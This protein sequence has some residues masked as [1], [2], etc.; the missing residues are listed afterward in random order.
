MSESKEVATR[1]P[2]DLAIP[3]EDLGMGFEDMQGQ[4]FA[5]PFLV[6]C[7]TTSPYINPAHELYIPEARPGTII[8]TMNNR[9]YA[10]VNVIPCKYAFRAVEWK[11]RASG[12][13]F[14]SSYTREEIP[15]D[16]SVNAI[17]GRTQRSNGNEI[18]STGY[19]LCLLIEEDFER[20]IVPMTSTQLK[21]SRK[22]N[23]MMMGQKKDGKPLPIFSKIYELSLVAEQ[24]NKG[25]WFG[26]KFDIV[27]NT[28]PEI[29]PLAKETNQIGN[30][31]PDQ[32]I[33]KTAAE[34]ETKEGVI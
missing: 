18:M 5:A 29:Y 22:W 19:Y 34:S 17:T 2:T 3:D 33:A 25:S 24:N 20:V 21:K 32:L 15:D 9:V 28:D 13:G 26:W 8:N 4:D 6:I 1:Q 14:V 30:F 7:Q 16:L 31:L 10:K 11:P 23:T 27:D 12:G